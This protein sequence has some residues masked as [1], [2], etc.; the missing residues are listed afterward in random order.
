MGTSPRALHLLSVIETRGMKRLAKESWTGTKDG[1]LRDSRI[2]LEGG[3]ATVGLLRRSGQE[4]RPH[5]LR[6]HLPFPTKVCPLDL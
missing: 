4:R 2:A 1:G 3:E 6:Y 5:S